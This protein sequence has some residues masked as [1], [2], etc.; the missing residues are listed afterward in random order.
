MIPSVLCGCG[1]ACY[2]CLREAQGNIASGL[3]DRLWW[4]TLHCSQ[5]FPVHALCRSSLGHFSKSSCCQSGCSPR[6]VVPRWSKWLIEINAKTTCFDSRLNSFFRGVFPACRFEVD[7][8]VNFCSLCPFPACVRLPCALG[9]L[10]VWPVTQT[11][12]TLFFIRLSLF[13]PVIKISLQASGFRL[14]GWAS[15]SR[16][17]EYAPPKLRGLAQER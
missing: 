4:K 8:G 7:E 2:T 14:Q 10:F 5:K 16:K 9:L 1:I 13:W 15:G 3:Q 12:V 17:R 6:F 11:K